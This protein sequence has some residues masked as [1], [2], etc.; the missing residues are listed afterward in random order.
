MPRTRSPVIK[1]KTAHEITFSP[2][3]DRVAF[4]GGR[5]VSVLHFPT[6][7]PVFAVHPIAHPSHID[8]SPDGSRLVVKSTL[9]RTVILDAQSGRTLKDFRNQ[10]EGEGS[11]AL[12][13]RCGRYVVSASWNGLLTVRDIATTKMVFSDL[14]EGGILNHLSAPRNRRFFAYSIGYRPL[15]DLQPPPPETIVLRPWPMQA[16]DSQELA[17]RW[18]FISALQVS[19]SG[20]LLAVIHGAPPEAIDIYDIERAR[21]IAQ[22]TVRFGGTGCSV[23]WSPDERLLAMNGDHRS[24]VLEMPKLGVMHEFSLRYSCY[25]G[26]SPSSR[27]VALGSWSTSFIVPVDYLAAFAES[28]RRAA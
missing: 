15:S 25:A 11:A 14:H 27:F 28:R 7:E 13:S 19:P 21:V 2:A 16:S 6:V 20:R 1:L 10:K 12:F 22:R 9:G 3:E 4:F 23:G 5:D 18:S 24:L 8:F 26:F 17:Q